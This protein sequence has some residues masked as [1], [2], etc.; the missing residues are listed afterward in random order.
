LLK[1]S[2]ALVATALVTTPAYA[3]DFGGI[4]VEGTAGYEDV[5]GNVDTADVAYG[6]SAGVNI[7]VGDL[8]VGAEATVDNVFDN[9]DVGAS[10][11]LGYV[12]G[13]FMPYAKVGYANYEDVTSR[14]LDGLRVGGGLEYNIGTNSYIKTEYRY[15][16][17]AGNT[18]KHSA[19]VGLG[20]RF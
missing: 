2:M 19:L 13:K 7:P 5:L 9:R 8:I 10:A 6:A 20:I 3:N 12:F 17:F 1:M 18:G 14:N 4:Y 16:D 15:T 11:K